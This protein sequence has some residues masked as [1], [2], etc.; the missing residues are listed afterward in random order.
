MSFESCLSWG[1][2]DFL[3]SFYLEYL[4]TAKSELLEPG[5]V[6]WDS[7]GIYGVFCPRLGR[8]L[9]ARV[10]GRLAHESLSR[11]EFPAVGDWVVVDGISD[12]ECRIL[13]VLPRRTCLKRKAAG[14]GVELQVLA[15]QIDEIWIVTSCNRDLSAERLERAL[16]L[17]AE[18]GA[19]ARVLLSKS[20]LVDPVELAAGI[21]DLE[22]RLPGVPVHAF[23]ARSGQG[24]DVIES[25]LKEA[26]SVVVIGS[27]GVGKSTLANHL[28]GR[29][30][31][32][33]GDVRED[34]AKGRHTT[35]GRSL[36]RLPSGAMLI[37]T[38]GTRELQVFADAQA[39]EV[40]FADVVELALGCKFTT[41]RHESEPGCAV[42]LALQEGRLSEDR[43]NNFQKL[44]REMAF[45]ARRKDKGLM[46]ENK[47]VWAKRSR[48]AALR[49]RNKGRS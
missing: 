45:Q 48:E 20:D 14:E 28:L 22:A 6:V 25:F 24:L 43:W 21:V 36:H 33:T 2:N 13:H 19:R 41:C 29:E 35:T 26:E 7:H 31:L 8:E 32:D 3:E 16:V 40:S 30:L 12:L 10:S 27:S 5:R 34:D 11:D 49:A 44:A 37:D 17:V 18:S 42:K 1:W 38:P 4:S 39:I 47:K 46:S 9:K 23:S 15:S